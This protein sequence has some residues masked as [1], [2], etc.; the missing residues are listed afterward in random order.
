MRSSVTTPS[1]TGVP[2]NSVAGAITTPSSGCSR[3]TGGGAM[4]NTPS[5]QDGRF[6]AAESRRPRTITSA[7]VAPAQSARDFARGLTGCCDRLARRA[8]HQAAVIGDGDEA[9][10]HADHPCGVGGCGVMDAGEFAVPLAGRQ[11]LFVDPQDQRLL[12]IQ[13]RN[14]AE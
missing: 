14:Q 13:R 1:T 6:K 7:A 12:A 10:A 4:T 5:V 2:G 8:C 11:Q 9:V 3:I